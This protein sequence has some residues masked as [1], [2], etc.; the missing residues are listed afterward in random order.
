MNAIETRE[1]TCTYRLGAKDFNRHQVLAYYRLYGTR[2]I[3]WHAIGSV[4]KGLMTDKWVA[5]LSELDRTRGTKL[6]EFDTP[7]EA[8]QKVYEAWERCLSF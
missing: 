5:T 1:V 6:G 7:E 8:A 3:N 2:P 4:Q